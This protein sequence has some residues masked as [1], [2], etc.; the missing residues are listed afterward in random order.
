MRLE[1]RD[2]A[3]IR[4]LALD[5]RLATPDQVRRGW[6]WPPSDSG[7]RNCR[8]RLRKLV[9]A[10]LLRAANVPST[11]LLDLKEPVVVWEPGD[12]S[13]DF[14]AA[15]HALKSRWGDLEERPTPV[16]MA[17]PKGASV[18]GGKGRQGYTKLD[19]ATHDLHVTELYIRIREDSPELA[20]EWVGEDIISGE[21]R[22]YEKL[23]DAEIRD[24]Q[25]TTVLYLEFGGRYDAREVKKKHDY[26]AGEPLRP[27]APHRQPFPYE[28]W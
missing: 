4:A 23:A 19:Q 21:L 14:D 15:S 26:F 16:Y 27:G 3:L 10:G 20:G 2:K 7:L 22:K 28:I 6:G 13:P 18:Y 1:T 12:P 17:S 25:G 24:H 11:P 8:E 9:D 5:V